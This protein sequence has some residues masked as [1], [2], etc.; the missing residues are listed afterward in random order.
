MSIISISNIENNTKLES[1]FCII[2]AGMSG[3][4][5]A[6]KIKNKKIIIVDSGDAN[7]DPTIQQLNEL[8]NKGLKLRSNHVNRVRQLGGSANLWANQLMYLDENEIN[9]REWLDKNLEWPIYYNELKKNYEEITN[10]IFG[11][12]FNN[13]DYFSFEKIKKYNSKLEN[14]FIDEKKLSF[15]NHFW[16][17]KMEKFNIKSKFTKKLLNNK[18]INLITNLTATHMEVNQENQ[19]VEEIL[20]QSKEKKIKVKSK[21]FVLSC[22]AIENAKIILNNS[23]NYKILSNSNTGRYYMDHPRVTLGTLGS[24]KK[25][26]LS[27]L[28][29]I[30]FKSFD[31]R[32]SLKISNNCQITSQILSS[33]AYLDPDFG[34]EDDKL[35]ESILNEIKKIIKFTGLPILKFRNI[36]LK[37]ILEQI[38]FKIP[39]QISNSYLNSVIRTILNRKNNFLSFNNIKINFQGEQF[40]NINSK[41]Y[42]S[43]RKD[44]FGQNI[45]VMDWRLSEV[46]HRT[47]QEFIKIL[48]DMTNNHSYLSFK[49]NENLEITDA[50]HH[51]GTTRMSLTKSDGVVDVNSKFHDIKN[52][53][54]SGNS[55]FRTIGSGNPGLTNMAMSNKLGKYLN[56]L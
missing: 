2:G 34:D 32:N 13:F 10:E 46:D 51:S 7:F 12:S 48:K 4:I 3:Q 52:L 21:V 49:E 38:Y 8:D 33:H 37:K 43:D 44:I 25:F 16:P 24:K 14:E 31:L 22:G 54:I 55:I 1:D 29:G 42:L 6:S 41:I 17:S 28:F 50:S 5:I 35:F 23:I 27:S 36:N 45:P 9:K 11:K 47:Q 40:P 56:K 20:F 26:S 15:K 30:K 39:P 19:M 53:Y 18:N